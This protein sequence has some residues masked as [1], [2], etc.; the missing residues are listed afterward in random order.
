MVAPRQ[1]EFLANALRRNTLRA[2][3]AISKLAAVEDALTLPVPA[4]V[5]SRGWSE[6][7]LPKRP[8][9]A[10]TGSM[11]AMLQPYHTDHW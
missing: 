8:N 4:L 2:P 6:K 5:V 11:K 7:I 1:L 10:N 3:P 9:F